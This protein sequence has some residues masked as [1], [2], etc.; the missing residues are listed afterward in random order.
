M[1]ENVVLTRTKDKSRRIEHLIGARDHLAAMERRVAPELRRQAQRFQA[2]LDNTNLDALAKKSREAAIDKSKYLDIAKHTFQNLKK[3][4]ALGPHTM[5]PG[6][7]LDIGAGAGF[8]CYAAKLCGHEA[9]A[10]QPFDRTTKPYQILLDLLGVAMSDQAIDEQQPIARSSPVTD[11]FDLITAFAIM[12][13]RRGMGVDAEHWT[14]EDYQFFL[15]DLRANLLRPGGRVVLKLHGPLYGE[16]D[17]FGAERTAYYCALGELLLPFRASHDHWNGAALNLFRPGAWE[18][19]QKVT[20]PRF[21]F[22][23]EAG[24]A[25]W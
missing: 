3:V 5:R 6:G 2:L 14:A 18:Q 13:N 19:A 25:R 20:L 9:I 1:G 22:S 12:F 8:F 24:K 15:D 17:D 11:R 21:K 16:E 10:I 7:V 23:D 4:R